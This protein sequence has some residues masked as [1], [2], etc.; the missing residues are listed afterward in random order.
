MMMT[1]GAA[2]I[3]SVA[4]GERDRSVSSPE[5]IPADVV[6]Q[7]MAKVRAEGLEL[8]GEGGV[9][10]EL[11]KTILERALDEELT[12]HVGYERGDPAGRGSGNSRNGTSP[13]RV[14]TEI[15]AIDVDVPRDRNG[16]FE[17]VIVPKGSTRLARFNAN[18]VAL[19]ARGLSTRDIRRELKRM[20]GVE[21]SP[22]LVSRVTDGVVEE[23]REWQ[24]RPLDAVY[25]IVYIDALVIKVRTQ[26]VVTNRP[27]Y[28]AIG[29][30]VDGRKH[31]FGVWLGDG[32]EGAK[33]WLSVLTEIRHRGVADV[34]FVCC[35]GLKGLP[36]AIEATWPAATVQ[37]C[38]IHLIR[39]SLRFASW[40]DRK[41]L[42]PAL[43]AIY[44]AVTVEAAAEALDLFELEHGDRYPGIV[45]LWRHA[46]EQ[47]IPFLAYPAVIRKIVYTTNMIESVNYQ[48]RKVTKTRGHF[49]DD[50]AALKLLR[51]VA[52]DL[53]TTRGG[54]AG[55]GTWG[56][57][58][59]LNAFEIHFPGRL[60][61][62]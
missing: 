17:P 6:D 40:K 42:M 22:D 14:L 39:A 27:A 4:G 16:S 12:D 5:P 7:L 10:A 34:I 9:L 28:L 38:V 18:V 33:F 48:L 44:T 32:G 26:G 30:D 62:C 57:N 21:V 56:W 58:E 49:P 29:V 19:Y 37:T 3:S 55:T 25:P 24:H 23:L 11:T 2:T 54:D 46:W 45:T 36:D 51:L 13:K 1:D 47:F 50:D 61:I 41:R 8:L 59:A 60:N 31:V 15:G 52:R 35:D 43:R 53:N 20:Y